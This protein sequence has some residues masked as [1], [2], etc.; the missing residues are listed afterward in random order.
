MKLYSQGHHGQYVVTQCTMLGVMICLCEWHRI[1]QCTGVR[2]TQTMLRKT[3]FN[4]QV[5]TCTSLQNHTACDEL[6]IYNPILSCLF[7][8]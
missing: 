7:L 8:N 3:T 1:G 2:D 6:E 4:I 5:Y